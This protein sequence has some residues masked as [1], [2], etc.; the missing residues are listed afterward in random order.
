MVLSFVVTEASASVSAVDS[1]EVRQL[2]EDFNP[3]SSSVGSVINQQMSMEMGT[4]IC[5]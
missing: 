4:E 2:A 5:S 1:E 3:E